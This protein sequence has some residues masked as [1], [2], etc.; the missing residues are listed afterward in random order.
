MN[1][2]DLNEK[3]LKYLMDTEFIST[4]RR[5]IAKAELLLKSCS[6]LIDQEL[7][8]GNYRIKSNYLINPPKISKGENYKGLPYIVLDNPRNYTSG[9]VLAY[10]IVIWWGN[11]ISFSLH[12]EGRHAQPAVNSIVRKLSN[13]TQKDLYYC[14]GNTPWEHHFENTNYQE[15]HKLKPESILKHFGKFQFLKVAKKATL[16]EWPF[17]NDLAIRNLQILTDLISLDRRS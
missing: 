12:L 4:K 14:L 6:K 17:L 16:K 1:S 5:I 13:H 8:S 2:F 11:T 10:R 15:L 7:R 3:E 9:N